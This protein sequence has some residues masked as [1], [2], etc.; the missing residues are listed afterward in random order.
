MVQHPIARSMAAPLAFF[1]TLVAGASGVA[2]AQPSAV[3]YVGHLTYA[4]GG[5][6]DG[7]VAVEAR[8]YGSPTNND[9]VWGPQVFPAVLVS[10][11]VLSIVL[12]EAAGVSVAAGLASGQPRYLAIR[13][14]AVDLL[15]RQ[16][17]L[18]VPYALEAGSAQR[19]GNILP[20]QVLTQ[21]DLDLQGT[22][23]VNGNLVVDETGEWVGPPP[24]GGSTNSETT[25][26]LNLYVNG[27]LGSDTNDG[28]SP[29]Q[30]KRTIQ[31]A[32]D[33]I[34]RRVL[35]SVQVHIAPGTYR[36]LASN[37]CSTGIEFASQRSCAVLI[38][39]F[40]VTTGEIHLIG[41]PLNPASVR[42]TGSDA[43]ADG[44]PVRH[45]G[46][47]VRNV[48]G[49]HLTGMRV[50]RFATE[51]IFYEANAAGNLTRVEALDNFRG[52][53]AI[54]NSR[55]WGDRLE[56]HG[57]ASVGFFSWMHA[58]AQCTD[59]NIGSVSKPNGQGAR[60]ARTS[61]LVLS[62]CR[63]TYNT[64]GGVTSDHHSFVAINNAGGT[65][66][67]ISNNAGVGL[68]GSTGTYVNVSDTTIS[69]NASHGIAISLQAFLV[70][71]NVSGSGNVGYGAYADRMSGLQGLVAGPIGGSVGGTYADTPTGAYSW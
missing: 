19:L 70:A 41:D 7:T 31:A 3:P 21:G 69:D 68:T 9:L 1:V 58:R 64:V 26:P 51:G 22:L 57:N 11:G 37:R 47:N 39:G 8:L 61:E 2:Q 65:T 18:S 48:F 25:G 35:H 38:T 59:C 52:V 6:F 42:I 23:S 5:A 62:S 33:T 53:M 28:L 54:E 17:V 66:S 36:D 16:Q 49:V 67:T 43:A 55:L 63:T 46:I 4:S 45:I 29:Q 56:V 34:P 44:V 15:P 71:T 27:S 24:A 10:R 20:S 13:I 32:I 14:G 40:D 30:A 50:D 60:A 12:T